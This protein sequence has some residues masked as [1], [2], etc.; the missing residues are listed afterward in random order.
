MDEV[1]PTTFFKHHLQK[2]PNNIN[3]TWWR[4]EAQHDTHDTVQTRPPPPALSNTQPE[5]LPLSPRKDEVDDQLSTDKSRDGASEGGKA[6]SQ[7]AKQGESGRRGRRRRASEGEQVVAGRWEGAPLPNESSIVNDSGVSSSIVV[8]TLPLSDKSA[9]H[10]AC[11]E[12]HPR[13]VRNPHHFRTLYLSN[14]GI[15]ANDQAERLI[16]ARRTEARYKSSPGSG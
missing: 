4:S 12:L 3:T 6:P 5:M 10:Q 8:A 14:L 13:M 2:R 11:A 7:P 15:W 16:S 9:S 1:Q